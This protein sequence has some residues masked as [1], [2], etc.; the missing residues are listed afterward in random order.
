M[1]KFLSI[2]MVLAMILAMST[3]AFAAG[4]RTYNAYQLLTLSVSLKHPNSAEHQAQFGCDG[5]NHKPECYA[6]DYEPNAKYLEIL[7]QETFAN[8]NANVWANEP[9]PQTAAGVTADQIRRHLTQYSG[10]SADNYG[11]VRIVLERMYDKIVA[12]GEDKTFTGNSTD[13]NL[14]Y[15]LFVDTTDLA[16]ENAANSLFIVDT[17]T[18]GTITITPKTDLPTIEKKVQDHDDTEAGKIEDQPW[19]D[20]ADH[21]INDL[22]PFKLTATLPNNAKQYSEYHFTFHDILS[23]GLTLQKETV[24]VLL[25]SSKNTADADYNLN[26]GKDIT[27]FFDVTEGA[28]TCGDVTGCS[29]EVK[30]NRDILDIPDVT[31]HSAIVVYYQAQL[32]NQAKLGN[33]GNPN[34]V[35]L[36]FSNNPNGNG[37]G[38]TKADKVTV[39]T[40]QIVINKVDESNHPLPGAEFKIM[41]YNPN[42]AKY[43]IEIPVTTNAEGTVFTWTGLDDGDYLLKETNAPDGYNAMKDI[44]FTLYATHDETSDDP[45]L[46]LL[47]GDTDLGQGDVASGII[48]K[49]IINK[50]GSIL[51]ETGAMGTMWLILGGTAL[52]ILAAVFMI[53]RKKMSVYED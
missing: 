50:T 26:G 45:Q 1:K 14:G 42:T 2:L 53:T 47:D 17:G 33:A 22:V 7:Q 48:E 46:T 12:L 43:D 49:N 27:E 10:D 38:L 30:S 6:Y 9:K 21:D 36:E 39:F 5:N 15:W 41:K 24:K 37:T 25:Y 19:H 8:G 11:T 16:G 34:T 40:Y 52:V 3:T 28:C 32:N 44:A 51:P 31:E 18:E 13:L 35:R 4:E 23:D 20:S 29:F